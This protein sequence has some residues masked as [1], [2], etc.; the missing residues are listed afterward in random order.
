MSRTKLIPHAQNKNLM[1]RALKLIVKCILALFVI[2]PLYL[3]SIFKKIKIGC[4]HYD[5]IGHLALNTD[6][7]LRRQQIYGKDTKALY[8]FLSGKPCNRQLLEMFK[9]HL[10]ILES[11]FA[12]RIYN[13]C[14]P[15][16]KRTRFFQPLPMNSNEYYEFNNADPSLFFTKEEEA[17]GKMF[18]ES[19]GI[20]ED[21]WF[22]CLFARD[23]AYLNSIYPD[24]DWSYHD[25]RNADIYSFLDACEYITTKGGYVLRVGYP[26]EKP[27][28]TDNP[29]I[30]DYSS[31]YRIDFLDI[32][33]PAKCKFFVG[34]TSGLADLPIIFD[35]P[36]IGTNHLPVCEKPIGKNCIY[37]PKIIKK[38]D[39][40]EGVPYCF[41]LNC[42]NERKFYDGN[43]FE[44]MGFI[45]EDNSPRDILNVTIEMNDKLDNVFQYTDEEIIL[46]KK[47]FEIF[48]PCN[49]SYNNKIPIG[50]KFLRENIDLF[51]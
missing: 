29:R 47:G 12:V 14:L 48:K 21:D 34:T 1:I 43:K 23:N 16:L 6:L 8:V 19:I 37:I 36:R 20:E 41:F 39:S 3:I 27:L 49:M 24:R 45:I 11:A 22:V 28:V 13:M 15:L 32:Y 18:L 30:I 10:F 33:L 9:S 26:V 38:R 35:V 5:R 17:K 31:K 40:G 25:Y 4:L 44:E 50:I 2:S 7:F 46:L 42:E 51:L